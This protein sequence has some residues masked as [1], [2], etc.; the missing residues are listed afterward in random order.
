MQ[1]RHLSVLPM[2]A[3]ALTLGACA[4]EEEPAVDPV[5]PAIEAGYD[6]VDQ[7]AAPVAT[8]PIDVR[9]EPG[10]TPA[11]TGLATEILG[12]GIDDDEDGLIDEEA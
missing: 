9:P 11:E 6:P 10:P 2:L 12:N 1:L 5:D 3:G 4:G 8:D 7:P